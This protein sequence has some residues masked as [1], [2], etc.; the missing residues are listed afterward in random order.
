MPKQQG[1]QRIN[2]GRITIL[3]VPGLISAVTLSLGALNEPLRPV[4]VTLSAER[5]GLVMG[6]RRGFWWRVT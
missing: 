6:G 1:I 4:P 3:F 5:S 2:S